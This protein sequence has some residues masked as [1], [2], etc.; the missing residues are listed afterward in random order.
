MANI[1]TVEVTIDENT[2]EMV[3]EVNGVKGKSCKDITKA[4]T[5]MGQVTQ[6]DN[7]CEAYEIPLP[8]PDHV[9]VSGS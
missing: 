8:A 9:N 7:T 3:V 1:P 4:L 5:Q 2:G 6:S